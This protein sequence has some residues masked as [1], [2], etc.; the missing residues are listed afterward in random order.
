MKIPLYKKFLNLMRYA[1]SEVF[2][3]KFSCGLNG[4]NV[5]LHNLTPFYTGYNN[6]LNSKV[7]VLY[8]Q[9]AWYYESLSIPGKFQVFLKW[10][11]KVAQC[12]LMWV[13]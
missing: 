1:C 4:P 3:T 10:G 12:G 11:I 2:D 6:S 5:N 13:Q 8:I 7:M 9:P